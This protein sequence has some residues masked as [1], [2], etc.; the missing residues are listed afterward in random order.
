MNQLF[1]RRIYAQFW[2]LIGLSLTLVGLCLIF[3]DESLTKNRYPEIIWGDSYPKNGL[4]FIPG[5]LQA[6][7]GSF[8]LFWK[9]DVNHQL[10]LVTSKAS[11]GGELPLKEERLYLFYYK[12]GTTSI[13]R[14]ILPLSNSVDPPKLREIAIVKT[15]NLYSA[16]GKGSP[17]KVVDQNKDLRTISWGDLYVKNKMIYQP[18][19]LKNESGSFN[20]AWKVSQ[21]NLV[22]LI[23]FENAAGE[24]EFSPRE[25]KLFILDGPKIGTMSIFKERLPLSNRQEPPMLQRMAIVKAEELN[26]GLKL[27]LGYNR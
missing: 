5:T 4:I 8:P 2:R 21:P 9:V 25:V 3:G 10:E 24:G 12:N 18:G 1:N 26:T 13:F 19:I 16:L 6:D 23:T 20:F 15:N 22:Q 27:V 11:G 7:F 17:I 14:E